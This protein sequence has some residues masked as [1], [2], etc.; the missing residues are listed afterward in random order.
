MSVITLLLVIQR[1]RW[2]L[3]ANQRLMVVVGLVTMITGVRDFAVVQLGVPGDGDIRWMTLGSLV[4]M[5]TLAWVMVQ[6]TSAYMQKMGDQKQELEARVAQKETELRQAFESLREAEKRQVLEAERERLTR[7]MHDGLGSQL[8]QTLNLVR[9]QQSN[10]PKQLEAMLGH[11]LEE[12]RMTLDSLEPM[13]GDLPAILGTLRQRISP[14]LA[15]AGIELDWQVEEVPA[16]AVNGQPMEPRAVMQLFRALQEIFANI[17]KHSLASKVSV[18]TWAE[19]QHVFLRVTDNGIGLGS[20]VRHGGRGMD[21]LR[22]RALALGAVLTLES[23]AV[24]D[25]EKEQG[26]TVTLRFNSL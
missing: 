24:E 26:T 12:L 10:D 7:D 14:T 8:V 6:R 4:F 23:P 2:G 20:G 3:D 16:V 13:E 17:V 11:A 15:A 9:A 21:N 22:G 25:P 18:R 1:A 19:G 5:L